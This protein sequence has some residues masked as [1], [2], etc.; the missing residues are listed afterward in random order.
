MFRSSGYAHYYK[1]EFL[2]RFCRGIA[3]GRNVGGIVFRGGADDPGGRPGRDK[4]E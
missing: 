3:P 1:S 4:I 2:A